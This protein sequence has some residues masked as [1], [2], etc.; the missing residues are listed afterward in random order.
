MRSFPVSVLFVT[1]WDMN[2]RSVAPVSIH[3]KLWVSGSGC[4]LIPP[5]TGG[6]YMEVLQIVRTSVIVRV[7]ELLGRGVVKDEVGEEEVVGRD[8]GRGRGDL[9]MQGEN[10]KRNLAEARLESPTKG[11]V[12]EK[13]ATGQP[14]ML[15]WK[16]PGVIVSEVDRN[17]KKNL[18]FAE[19]IEQENNSEKVYETRSGTPP[20]PPSAR[21]KKRPKKQSIQGKDKN[22]NDLAASMSEDR[23]AK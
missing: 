7:E 1:F 6:S 16:E 12:G 23:L 4:W 21:E 2:K 8:G 20:P 22:S 14:L 11:D 3:R 10:R 15:Q 9:S 13:G 17:V 18:N 19:E 5:G